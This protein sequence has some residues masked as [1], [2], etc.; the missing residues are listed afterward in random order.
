[1]QSLEVIHRQNAEEIARTRAQ[2]ERRDFSV[3]R[4]DHGRAL[5]LEVKHT[6]HPDDLV[7]ATYKG[8]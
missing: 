4:P 2:A 7:L 3:V 5:H 1:M 6:P 8:S